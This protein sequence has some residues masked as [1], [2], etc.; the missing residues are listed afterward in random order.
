MANCHLA[1]L[2]VFSSMCLVSSCDK[3]GRLKLEAD[4]LISQSKALKQELGQLDA[5]LK[6][7]G[8][9]GSTY[10]SA[11]ERQTV[12]AVVKAEADE[13]LAASKTH[14]SLTIE[15]ALKDLRIRVDAWKAKHLK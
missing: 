8:T 4:E 13:R 3:P 6:S 11:L 12:E 5:D 9:Q 14:R 1:A 7:L 15:T 2:V 10:A